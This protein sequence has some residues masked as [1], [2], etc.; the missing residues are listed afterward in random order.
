MPR[1][2]VLLTAGEESAVGSVL[3]EYQGG[4]VSG[5]KLHADL[6]ALAQEHQGQTV[7][8]E[9]QGPLGWMRFLWCQK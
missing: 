2:L 3:R 9:W 6:Q 5:H 1:R 8:A 7:A 4:E